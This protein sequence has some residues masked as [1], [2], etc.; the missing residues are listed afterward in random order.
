VATR[1]LLDPDELDDDELEDDVLAG[2]DSLE[3]D[4]ARGAEGRSTPS[5]RSR[6][7]GFRVAVRPLSPDDDL[8]LVSPLVSPRDVVAPVPLELEPLGL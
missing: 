1:P 8:P 4:S 7:G 5:D 6:A 2:F 3:L